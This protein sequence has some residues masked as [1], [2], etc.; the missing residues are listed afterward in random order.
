MAIIRYLYN[1]HI[2]TIV[3]DPKTNQTNDQIKEKGFSHLQALMCMLYVDAPSIL[4][5]VGA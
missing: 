4:H 3:I 1:M 5:Q 2:R